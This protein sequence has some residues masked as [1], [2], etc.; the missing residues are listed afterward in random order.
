MLPTKQKS[1]PA[2]GCITCRLAGKPTNLSFLSVNAT[3]DGVVRAPSAFSIT[4]GFCR[5]QS[6]MSRHLPQYCWFPQRKSSTKMYTGLKARQATLP[7]RSGS[8]CHLALHDSHTR[9]GCSQVNT[10][11]V[12]SSACMAGRTG[13]ASSISIR[14]CAKILH[15]HA[16]CCTDLKALRSKGPVLSGR[17]A[18]DNCMQH[19][20]DQQMPPE[21]FMGGAQIRTAVI[22][23]TQQ[24]RLFWPK[25][26]RGPVRLLSPSSAETSLK[27]NDSAE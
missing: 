5:T 19:D 16:L 24:S 20:L 1:Q 15:A 17:D 12:A 18:S 4:L 2:Q 8:L 25:Q 22:L 11:D 14:T 6:D 26:T 27:A 21:T 9:V 3:T 7:S 23:G 13:A 10:N